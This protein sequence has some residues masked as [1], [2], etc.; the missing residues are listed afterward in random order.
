MILH[1]FFT[2]WL[3]KVVFTCQVTALKCW[4]EV[5]WMMIK[6]LMEN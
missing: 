2:E 5:S 4:R 3:L 1:K 6:I